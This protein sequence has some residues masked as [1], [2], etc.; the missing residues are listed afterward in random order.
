MKCNGKFSGRALVVVAGLAIGVVPMLVGCDRKDATLESLSNS[1]RT[2]HS[3]GN[4]GEASRKQYTEV[5]NAMA[6][7]A[8]GGDRAA[9]TASL[10]ISVSQLGLTDAEFQK[11][12]TSESDC[13]ALS[14]QIR[15]SL[16]QY[17]SMHEAAKGADAFSVAGEMGRING[18]RAT[19][20]AALDKARTEKG[21][22]DGDL[23]TL[24]SDAKSR[25]DAAQAKL[26]E[27]AKLTE[28]LARMSATEAAVATQKAHDIKVQAES[29]R[30]AGLELQAQAATLEPVSSEWALKITQHENLL[31]NLADSEKAL[32]EQ[33]RLAKQSAA[34]ARSDAKKAGD[35]VIELT[36]Q[37]QTLRSGAVDESATKA[38]STLKKALDA[39]R[40][41][42][43]PT[44]NAGQAGLVAG[45][46]QQGIGELQW[47]RA[48]GH[49]AYASLLQ[50]L[51]TA[52]PALPGAA[53]YASKVEAAL[54]AQ[55]DASDAAKA[56]FEDAQRGFERAASASTGPSNA[57]AKEQL[58]ALAARYAK[59]SGKASDTAVDAGAATEA[60]A[61]P[62][63]AAAPAA[64]AGASY[65]PELRKAIESNLAI[66]KS[67][68]N[69]DDAMKA[70]FGKGMN[71][72]MANMPG[73]GQAMSGMSDEAM[74]N[75]LAAA[76]VDAATVTV[77]G[78]DATIEIT[79]APKLTAKKMG[80]AWVVVL[81]GMEAMMNNP[82]MAAQAGMIAK[83]M[84]AI[85]KVA[86][87]LA[88]EIKDGK[89]A[90]PDTAM[91][92]FMEKMMQ[93]LMGGGG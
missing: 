29:D 59:L 34:D 89:H 70:K 17:L 41:L 86:D 75:A 79:G 25:L 6:E 32:Q 45:M 54:K 15:S 13:L 40:E 63:P 18:D 3:S 27:A 39:S 72:L 77:N 12:L 82:Q 10:M 84:G 80:E 24:K 67:M 92:A 83:S 69:L 57:A 46:A 1:A 11:Y 31:K 37:L 56:A 47:A 61:A 93:A 71:E 55:T 49:E 87:N 50:R 68:K 91:K 66:A 64:T 62:A 23:T 5:S 60:A 9:A 44:G 28:N 52:Q 21:K 74:T 38:L 19:S 4:G 76:T 30:R 73:G 58:K 16:S 42:A 51:T 35:R 78:S 22:V 81:P 20:Q 26:A 88:Q 90:T 8:K 48:K 33:E 14:H 43:K 2:L 53:D 7:V 36:G 85:G 65:D